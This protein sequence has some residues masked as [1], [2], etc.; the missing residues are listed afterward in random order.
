VA[1]NAVSVNVPG[2]ML[3]SMVVTLS[4]EPAQEKEKRS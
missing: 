2:G 4:G 1:A 3:T